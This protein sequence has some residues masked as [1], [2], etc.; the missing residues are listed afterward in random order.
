MN[1]TLILIRHAQADAR[2]TS[3]PDDSR[4]PLVAK[5]H[6]QAAVLATAF[7]ALGITLD[8]LYS[9]PFVR[10][11]ET[12]EPLIAHLRRGRAIAYLDSLADSDYDALLTDLRE[13][14]EP[15]DATVACVGHEPFL[16]EFASLLLSGDPMKVDALF[17]KSAAM[18]SVFHILS[19]PPG[20]QWPV[21]GR[22]CAGC[23]NRCAGCA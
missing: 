7:K 11:A 17:R 21:T 1:V 18:L 20:T 14:F 13:R 15:G 10:A 6:R 8:R 9:S 2:G 22:E 16:S 19:R 12:A 4:R 5:G 3:F 23:S